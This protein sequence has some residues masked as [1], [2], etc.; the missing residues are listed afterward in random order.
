MSIFDSF[1]LM[2]AYSVNL[3]W[4]LKKIR[5]LEEYV[6]NYTAVN[7]VAYAG[8][9]DI[10]KQYPQWALV[11]D[12]EASYLALQPVPVGIPIDNA[13]YWQKLAD[14]DPRISGI[15]VQLSK[16]NSIAVD[17]VGDIK[18]LDVEAGNLVFTSGFYTAGDGGGNAYVIRDNVTADNMGIF[19]TA[20]P[21]LFAVSISDDNNIAKYGASTTSDN[22]DIIAYVVAKFG[23]A[24]VPKGVYPC[25]KTIY[26]YNN[27]LIGCSGAIL[28]ST[29]DVAIKAGRSSKVAN[30]ELRG[31]GIGILCNNVYGLQRTSIDNIILDGFDTAITDDRAHGEAIFSVSFNNLE[32]IRCRNGIVLT[33]EYT[34]A[35]TF[36][37]VYITGNDEREMEHGVYITGRSSSMMFTECNVEH[38]TFLNPPFQVDD[39]GALVI[40]CL[41]LEKCFYNSAY[42]G[43]LKFN[44]TSATIGSLSIVMCNNN[45]HGISLIKLE[46]GG[47]WGGDGTERTTDGSQITIDNLV[48]WGINEQNGGLTSDIDYYTI[49][50]PD[51]FKTTLYRVSIGNYQW[52]TFRN[53]GN[54]LKGLRI[55]DYNNIA[56]LQLPITSLSGDTAP[57]YNNYIGKVFKENGVLKM[58]DGN[59]WVAI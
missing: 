45:K 25:S 19:A 56:I 37:N 11:T 10:T 55:S 39:C 34:T 8:V 40:G 3:D 42:E 57:D 22:S 32:I 49:F 41:H 21:G 51:A 4:I 1:P 5:E 33:A 6:Q 59:S 18:S 31:S 30:I 43:F 2:N 47:F 54:L 52:F 44:R 26:L 14:L 27:D 35:S 58:F 28:E 46:N 29:A 36:N 16:I 15:I 23:S 24:F 7:N 9:W 50:R 20:K 38:A 13:D 12:G 17:T 53:D 48:V